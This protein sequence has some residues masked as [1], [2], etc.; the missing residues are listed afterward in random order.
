MAEELYFNHYGSDM[1]KLHVTHSLSF[2]QFTC[3]H[4]RKAIS[5]VAFVV[6]TGVDMQV[7]LVG[8]TLGPKG[9]N[10]VLQKKYGLPRL[11]VMGL[12]FLKRQRFGK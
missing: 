6:Q 8:V 4:V 7:E 11:L 5:F 1:N 12:L 10:V 9:R 2:N 3:C